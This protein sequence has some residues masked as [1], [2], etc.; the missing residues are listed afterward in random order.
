MPVRIFLAQMQWNLEG[1]A[2]LV[3]A[4]F[5]APGVVSR[6]KNVNRTDLGL[7]MEERWHEIQFFRQVSR[8]S[9]DDFEVLQL[10]LVMAGL[11]LIQALHP[12]MK[13]EYVR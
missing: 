1:S 7:S 8:L 3:G 2:G 10:S 4:Q 6:I 13:S 11:I 9:S 5:T 12:Q